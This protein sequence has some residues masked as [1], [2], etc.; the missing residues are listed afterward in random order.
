MQSVGQPSSP[1]RRGRGMGACLLCRTRKLKCDKN[2]RTCL[3]CQRARKSCIAIDPISG[4]QYE[5]GYLDDLNARA[6]FLRRIIQE[7]SP[8]A[9]A[10][11]N[12]RDPNNSSSGVTYD[13]SKVN[14]ILS[15]GIDSRGSIFNLS[16]LVA[17]AVS[18]QLPDRPTSHFVS[19]VTN[20]EQNSN[21]AIPAVHVGLPLLSVAYELVAS[22]FD[23]GFHRVSPFLRRSRVYEQILQLFSEGT[24]ISRK[25]ERNN[26]YQIFMVFAIGAIFLRK[27]PPSQETPIN[28]YSTAM[29]YSDTLYDCSPD[30]QIQNTLLLIVF[31]HQHDIGIGSKWKLSRQAMRIC[32]QCGYHRAPVAPQEPVTEQMQ[33]RLF[34]CS[35]VQERFSSC[36]LGRP[37]AIADTDITVE[38]PSDICLD[39]T[40]SSSTEISPIKSEVSV[41]KRQVRLRQITT[42]VQEKLYS[43]HSRSLHNF[44][45]R[46]RA[47]EKLNEELEAWRSLH[48]E[49][50]TDP[51]S[52]CIFETIEYME[53]NF[54]RE[55]INIFSG[56]AVP[57]NSEW[58]NFH[59]DIKHLRFCFESSVE[60]IDLYEILTRKNILVTNWTYVQDILRSGFMIL[61]CGIHIPRSIIH[62]GD[63]LRDR[64]ELNS[65][66]TAMDGCRRVLKEISHKWQTVNPHRVVYEKLA[67][68]VK[69]L[70]ET[71]FSPFTDSHVTE[72]SGSLSHGTGMADSDYNFGDIPFSVESWGDLMQEDVDIREIFGFDM[73]TN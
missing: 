70:I 55:R 68:E 52:L 18:M 44:K 46:E 66:L 36:N 35:Y 27:R 32:V 24:Q 11:Q 8:R 16:H 51:N 58:Q 34:W 6:A 22:Y 33:R 50:S 59:P 60:I 71:T 37:V 42:S 30:V 10:S 2:P 1:D 20:E 64:R 41:L 48:A 25:E 7:S 13:Q 14:Q 53:I 15:L 62:D 45:D 31:A 21:K 9:H 28:Y 40:G 39:S 3:N 73:S 29:Q 43:G 49:D 72:P 26:M 5:R 54:H 61:F 63:Y 67:D 17:A 69:R 12:G 38:L 4:R 23:N 47:A 57:S 56:L 65:I 19:S